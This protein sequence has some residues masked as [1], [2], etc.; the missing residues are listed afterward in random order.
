M[1]HFS[2]IGIYN[3]PSRSKNTNLIKFHLSETGLEKMMIFLNKKNQNFLFKSDF[4][5]I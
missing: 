2:L 1:P 4:F 3:L 5:L